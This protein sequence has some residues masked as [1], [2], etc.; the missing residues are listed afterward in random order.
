MTGD[1]RANEAEPANPPCVACGARQARLWAQARDVEYLSCDDTFHYYHCGACGVLFIDPVPADRLADIYP[2]NYYSFGAAESSVVY[3]IKA[4][5]DRRMFRRL[6]RAVPGERLRVL[7]VGGGAG[8][9]LA[10][11]RDADP[12]V[13][14]TQVVDIDPGAEAQ[15]QRNGHAYFRGR[16]EDFETDERFE[17]VLVLNLIEHVQD[18]IALLR[19][20][21]GLLA[22][23][24]VVL[25]KTPNY[26]SLD[27]RLFRHANW[28]GYHCPRHWV[29]FDR[30]SFLAAAAAAGLGAVQCRYTQGAP[31]WALSTLAWGARRGWT[32]ITTDRPATAHP[33]FAPLM[34]VF[35][36]F[37]FAVVLAGGKTSQMVALLRPEQAAP[38]RH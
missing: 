30:P 16:I 20:L 24:G 1:R 12:R 13:A 32:A 22:P 5:L 37:D 9:Q 3:R 28:G 38:D 4:G 27:A 31:F 35:A 25:V 23:G 36:A 17:A 11:V 33:L 34:G 14:F 15:A 8:W 2:P 7:D 19:K 21:R 10:T 6:L 18:P 29:L 26:R